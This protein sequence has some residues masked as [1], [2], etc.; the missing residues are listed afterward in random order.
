MDRGN[1]LIDPDRPGWFRLVRQI[2]VFFLGI[3]ILLYA[4]ASQGHDIPFLI[5]GLVLIGV[6]P[7]DDALN[8]WAERRT[9]RDRP[10]DEK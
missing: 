10:P 9:S 8:R 2:I 5:T 4:V 3:A 1:H 7:M 6:V